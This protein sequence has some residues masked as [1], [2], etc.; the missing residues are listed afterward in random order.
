MAKAVRERG[1][2][3]VERFVT[4]PF[5]PLYY[6][7]TPLPLHFDINIPHRYSHG[8]KTHHSIMPQADRTFLLNT[9]R[10]LVKPIAKFCLRHTLSIQDLIESAKIAFIEVA[11]AEIRKKGDKVNTSRI[12]LVTGLHRKD[13]IRNS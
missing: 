4:M 9:L 1:Q 2:R 7:L 6:S 5:K 8:N 12:S 13:V 11:D 3:V 10:L